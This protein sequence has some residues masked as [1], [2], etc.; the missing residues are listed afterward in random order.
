MIRLFRVLVPTSVVALLVSEF[1][2]IYACY[3][4][5]A[6]LVF[7]VA[8][9]VFLVDDNGWLR[10]GLVTA[11]L[12]AAVYFHDL[13]A[14]LRVKSRVLLYQQIGVVVGVAFLVQSVLAYGRL[15]TL[16]LPV[17]VMIAGSALAIVSLPAWRIFYARF[18][19]KL[20]ASERVLF[21]GTSPI[22]L[23]IIGYLA[24][25]PEAGLSPVGY[26]DDRPHAAAGV[27]GQH[28]GGIAELRQVVD[29]WKPRRIVVGLSE[30]RQ[31]LPVNDLLEMRLAGVYIEDALST[32]E[33]MF[34][35]VSTRELRPSQLIFSSTEFGPNP[36]RVKLQCFYSN[37]I[38]VVAAVCAAPMVV[39][40]VILI[41]IS[42]SGPAFLRQ[43][44]VG[45][46]NR[47]FTL[48]KLRSMYAN[49]EASGGAVW[50]KLR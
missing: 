22:S 5:A 1:I 9:Q 50:A 24:E 29:Q 38:A 4:A 28:L 49:A 33:A 39:L 25:H 3:L 6:F 7:P 19:L 8:P 48:Y 43:H 11:C 23:E 15:R 13:Y 37:V 36:R 12:M 45:K 26:V 46:N 41:K 32:Y 14:H 40:A 31:R 16:M 42:S 30:R 2:L 18:V 34:D 27:S 44:R 21:L 47:I 10:I 35:R 17:W 20:L